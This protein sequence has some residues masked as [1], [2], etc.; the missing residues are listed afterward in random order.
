VIAKEIWDG[1]LAFDNSFNGASVEPIL[2]GSGEIALDERWAHHAAFP[3]HRRA[4]FVEPA[5]QLRV[6]RGAV[7][8]VLHIVFARPGHLY[9]RAY[10][11]GKLDSLGDEVLLRAAAESTSEI[12]RVDAHLL[13]LEAGELR[14]GVLAKGLEL[15]G[16]VDVAT[17]GADVS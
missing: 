7:K 9:R 14:A 1:V 13:G 2:H 15:R 8:V 17:V 16:G 6:R 11:L 10:R 12:C 5:R 4:G 3:G